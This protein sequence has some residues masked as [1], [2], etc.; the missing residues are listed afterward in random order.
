[1]YL[2]Y[3]KDILKSVYKY[4]DYIIKYL[5]LLK[6]TKLLKV[7]MPSFRC[8]SVVLGILYLIRGSLLKCSRCKRGHG[9][10]GCQYILGLL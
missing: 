5:K 9:A 2:R 4:V 7:Y 1:M 3:I 6:L 10:Q 8:Y